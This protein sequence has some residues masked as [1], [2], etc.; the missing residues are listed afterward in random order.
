MLTNF[1]RTTTPTSYDAGSMRVPA[2]HVAAPCRPGQDEG[3]R[4]EVL[5]GGRAIDVPCPLVDVAPGRAVARRGMKWHGM[6]VEFVQ[7][8]SHDRIE[9]SFHSSV[10][11]LAAYQHGLRRDGESYVEG[12]PPSKLRDLA[13]KLTF[14]PADH[15]YREWHDPRTLLGVMYIYFDP[16][17][18][19]DHIGTRDPDFLQAPR[20]LF[21][22]AAIWSTVTKLKQAIDTPDVESRLYVEALG[23][24]LAHELIRLNRGMPR[25]EEPVRGGLAAWQQ[26]IVTGYIDEHLAEQISLA[27]LAQLARLSTYHFCRAFKQSFGVP[28][29]RYHTNRR[30]EQAKVM[31]ASREHSVTEIGLTLGFSETSSFTAAFRK[32]TGQTP[33]SYHRSLG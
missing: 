14:V 26:R 28:P 2:H 30:I 32:I 17:R 19:Q 12:L 31:L 18:L 11:L 29:H 6:G 24:V 5:N 27:T 33:S 25:A 8:T 3:R 22:D 23:L 13:K 21:E 10:H 9:C 4:F 1:L 7:M 15:D 20:L 16:A